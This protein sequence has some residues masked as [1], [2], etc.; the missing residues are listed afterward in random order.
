MYAA[1]H[2]N[3]VDKL[4]RTQQ[5]LVSAGKVARRMLISRTGFE[6]VWPCVGQKEPWDTETQQ[7]WHWK[8]TDKKMREGGRDGEKKRGR[9]EE[10]EEEEGRTGRNK[11]LISSRGRS[12][13]YLLKKET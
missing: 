12:V 1:E 10:D 5:S 9:V 8:Q 13:R 4:A 6:C 3:T 7:N 11:Y 2:E